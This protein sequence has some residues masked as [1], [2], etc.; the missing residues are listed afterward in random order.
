MIGGAFRLSTW[1][2]IMRPKLLGRTGLRVSQVCLGTMT[3]G[4]TR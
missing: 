4:D 1:R 3:F 2:V